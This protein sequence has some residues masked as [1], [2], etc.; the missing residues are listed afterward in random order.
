MNYKNFINYKKKNKI[1]LDKPL[2]LLSFQNKSRGGLLL[3]W[4]S[5]IEQNKNIVN[6]HGLILVKYSATH[7]WSISYGPSFEL[8]A[9][10][11]KHQ[12]T[13]VLDV[14]AESL[15]ASRTYWPRIYDKTAS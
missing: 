7:F 12:A 3:M 5:N 2:A 9:A 8:R 15:N 11:G 1:I 4:G 10:S 14:W 6:D 13:I